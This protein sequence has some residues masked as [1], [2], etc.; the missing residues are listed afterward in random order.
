M[1]PETQ[2]ENKWT[3]VGF[4]VFTRTTTTCGHICT[5]CLSIN[6]ITN[7]TAHCCKKQEVT[8]SLTPHSQ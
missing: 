8:Y 7:M 2:T 5:I 3:K 4:N 1:T 6:N